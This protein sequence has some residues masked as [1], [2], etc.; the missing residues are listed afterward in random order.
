[1]LVYP[2]N[3]NTRQ[4]GVLQMILKLAL[5]TAIFTM[6]LLATQAG[7]PVV[8]DSA[9]FWNKATTTFISLM[10]LSVVVVCLLSVL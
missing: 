7:R 5:A 1:M 8:S 4:T 2:H 3:T 6:V 10:G 9:G